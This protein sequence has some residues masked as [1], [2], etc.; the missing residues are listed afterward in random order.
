MKKKQP[1]QPSI[2]HFF[3]DDETTG[4]AYKNK[5]R[6]REIINYL[7][8]N[9]DSTIPDLA[10]ALNISIPKT[11]L[12]I[13]ELI[14]DGLIRDYGK[15]DSLA[16]RPASRY[17]LIAESCFFM[18]VDVH[19]YYINI[20]ILDFKKNLASFNMRIPY[21][22]ANTRE[23]LNQ[24]IS[25]IRNFI[26]KAP[27][28]SQSILS[29]CINLSGRI[30]TSN[31]HSYSFFHFEEEPL[32]LVIEKQI[33][34]RTFL[35]NDSRAMAYGEFY[36]G[37][38]KNEKNVLFVNM[39]YGIGLGILIDRKVYYGKSGYSGEFGHI[40]LFDNEII[41]HCGKK[42]CLETEA[43]GAALVRNFKKK[44]KQGSTS[45]VVASPDQLDQVKLSDIIQG[46]KHEDVLSID[47]L[48]EVGEKMGRGLAVLINI[49]NA[50]MVIL[51]G[52]LTATGDY[53]YLPIKSAINKYSLN[54]V[55]ND[56]KLCI[57]QLE[58]KAGVI[59]GCLIARNKIIRTA[60]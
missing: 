52:T 14:E 24:L 38:V 22:L 59:G 6:K 50:E 49:F 57:S 48:A 13:N 18:G 25:I 15:V 35:E 60:V 16:G 5:T 31:G 11:T 43:S 29:L 19:P 23:S 27:V 9:G 3:S 2:L 58:E 51:G 39:D 33:G 32:A 34:I 30:N 44:I 20:G 26:K 21:T 10:Q 54:L 4:V 45:S 17:G 1:S 55:N 46:A 42:G 37:I 12:L 7:D 53:I 56:T 47:L 41:C 8:I 40:P 28:K 36:K